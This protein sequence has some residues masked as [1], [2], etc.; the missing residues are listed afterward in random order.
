MLRIDKE[1]IKGITGA[2][3]HCTCANGDKN[4]KS[5]KESIKDSKCCEGSECQIEWQ[6]E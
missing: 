1:E 3:K 4:T 5:M 2:R 6:D